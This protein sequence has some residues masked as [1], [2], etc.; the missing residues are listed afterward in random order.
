MGGVDARNE[1]EKLIA[2]NNV[3]AQLPN[4]MLRQGAKNE[5]KWAWSVS[6][7]LSKSDNELVNWFVSTILSFYNT[8]ERV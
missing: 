7:T 5:G 4:L 3:D 1:M 2:S 8:F 6:D